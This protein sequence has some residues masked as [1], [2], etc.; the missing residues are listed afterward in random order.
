M[1]IHNETHNENVI[2]H[3]FY[4]YGYLLSETPYII[5]NITINIDIIIV[6]IIFITM[7]R[8]TLVLSFH[9]DIEFNNHELL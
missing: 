5:I 2:H 7:Y 6:E 1:L 8:S 3:E 9:I 4:Y